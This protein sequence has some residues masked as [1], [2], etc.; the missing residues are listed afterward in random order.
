MEDRPK[1]L[2]LYASQTGNALDA[3]EQAAREADR[4]GCSVKLLSLDEYDAVSLS[5]KIFH[6]HFLTPVWFPRKYS[7]K[8][9]VYLHAVTFSISQ[10]ALPY[11]SAVVFVV[12]T[13]GQGDTP[14]SMKVR[15]RICPNNDMNSHNDRNYYILAPCLC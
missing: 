11:E 9:T 15:L 4:R 12:S 3:A 1:L 10:I 13:T 5:F 6:F 7:G 8:F 2:I 14:D